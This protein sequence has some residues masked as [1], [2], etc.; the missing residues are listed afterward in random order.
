MFTLFELLLKMLYLSSTSSSSS[1]SSSSAYSSFP[2]SF[3]LRIGNTSFN[4][5]C[6]LQGRR[7]SLFM[8]LFSKGVL[9]SLPSRSRFSFRPADTDKSSKRSGN[10][11][12]GYFGPRKRTW[13]FSVEQ[14][15]IEANVI[16]SE[17]VVM[18]LLRTSF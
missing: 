6:T 12:L 4:K 10:A 1:S 17:C 14:N 16:V 8:D 18:T 11:F 2:A 9:N 5:Q 7:L 13:F 3:V 15:K